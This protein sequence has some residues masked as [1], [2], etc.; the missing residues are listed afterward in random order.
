MA[1]HFKTS[2]FVYDNVDYYELTRQFENMQKDLERKAKEAS[3]QQDASSLFN[4]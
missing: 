2:P 3:G 4:M 1:V